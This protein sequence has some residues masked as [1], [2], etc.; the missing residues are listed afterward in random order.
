MQTLTIASQNS[1]GPREIGVATSS[2]TFFRQIGGTL[3]VA[4][5]FSVLFARIPD[6]IQAAFGRTETLRN[7]LD[8]ALDPAVA[9]APANAGIMDQV[10]DDIVGPVAASLPPGVD[11]ADDSVRSGVLDTLVP[12]VQDAMGGS[13]F[14]GASGSLDGDT[15]FL[16]GADARLAAPFLDGFANAAVTVFWVS[17]VV[18]LVAFVLSF[19]LKT[20]PL[21]MKSAIEEVAD[22]DAALLAQRAADSTAAMVEP[23][24]AA[25]DI[26]GGS[27]RPEKAG[28]RH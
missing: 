2:S 15:S 11:L 20:P 19:F 21:R 22:A 27:P 10:Y 28:S 4:I 26:P 5:L 1:V 8:A 7:A 13:G 16:T 23:G 18:V 17:L 14:G 25:H 12:Q 3:G 24:G 6:T 9:S